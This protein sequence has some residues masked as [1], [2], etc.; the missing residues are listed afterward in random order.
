MG[1]KEWY[2]LLS[3]LLL[4][5]CSL[6]V[7]QHGKYLK[8]IW[9]LLKKKMVALMMCGIF[10]SRGHLSDNKRQ[11]CCA[12]LG[13]TLVSVQDG[14]NQSMSN[15]F[16][17]SVSVTHHSKLVF[18]KTLVNCCINSLSFFF[19]PLTH[20]FSVLK[21]DGNVVPLEPPGAHCQPPL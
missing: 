14:K 19:P 15:S 16:L 11:P 10:A 4:N 2:P 12:G 8:I 6:G 5:F 9:G 7:L 18:L 20:I 3:V 13:F 1:K 17:S 21:H